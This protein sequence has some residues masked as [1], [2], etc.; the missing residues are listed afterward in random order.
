MNR[1]A[2]L[3]AASLA[4]CVH[5]T[6]GI[7]HFANVQRIET[8][9]ASEAPRPPEGDW[10]CFDY[11]RQDGRGD[12]CLQ[13]LSDCQRAAGSE[14]GAGSCVTQHNVACSYSFAASVHQCYRSTESCRSSVALF[15]PT[16]SDP[17]VSECA[18]Y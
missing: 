11:Q 4:G 5:P 8:V 16:G 1:I 6:T 9:A 7:D 14:T 12:R 2:V 10:Q 3:V 18:D 15:V 17:R 13:T